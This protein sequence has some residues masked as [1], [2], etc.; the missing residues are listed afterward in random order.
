MRTVMY[1]M[2]NRTL[3]GV[4]VAYH[5]PRHVLYDLHG[6]TCVISRM[7]SDVIA[8]AAA[9]VAAAA[10]LVRRRQ[11]HQQRRLLAL[12]VIVLYIS[13]YLM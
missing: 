11:L 3:Y 7:Y 4:L 13:Y 6:D 10:A 9:A 2:R 1:C 12:V 5:A 8:I